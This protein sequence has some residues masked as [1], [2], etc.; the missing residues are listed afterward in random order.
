MYRYTRYTYVYMYAGILEKFPTV[1]RFSRARCPCVACKLPRVAIFN[2][3]VRATAGRSINFNH[4]HSPPLRQ[5][6]LTCAVIGAASKTR[7]SFVSEGIYVPQKATS[8]WKHARYLKSSE[9]KMKRHRLQ[10]ACEKEKKEKKKESL[11][12][13]HASSDHQSE[14]SFRT[15]SARNVPRTRSASDSLF[16]FFFFFG[17]KK[18]LHAL[19]RFPLLGEAF[20][21]CT[22]RKRVFQARLRRVHCVF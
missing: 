1:L 17:G 5:W 19:E 14:E 20:R 4:R 11:R 7:F 6:K 16:F 3:F 13:R 15:S 9:T 21:N 10:F 12:K 2:G 18:I 22:R 8:W